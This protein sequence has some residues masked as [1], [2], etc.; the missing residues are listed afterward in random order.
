MARG[1]YF[2]ATASWSSSPFLRRFRGVAGELKW[3][4]GF[5]GFTEKRIASISLAVFGQGH[6]QMK[7]EQ[8]SLV[9]SSKPRYYCAGWRRREPGIVSDSFL[10]LSFCRI[11][12]QTPRFS[13]CLG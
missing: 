10:V 2:G 7:C 3:M 13:A 4:D 6:L 8:V 1:R 11:S 5:T 12:G 9:P